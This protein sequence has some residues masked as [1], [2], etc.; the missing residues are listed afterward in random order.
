MQAGKVAN[1]PRTPTPSEQHTIHGENPP[2]RKTDQD[3][4]RQLL[5]AVEGLSM[6]FLGCLVPAVNGRSSCQQIKGGSHAM[7]VFAV[8]TTDTRCTPPGWPR[9][10]GLERLPPNRAPEFEFCSLT[11]RAVGW[12]VHGIAATGRAD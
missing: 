12:L 8:N 7:T 2:D 10:E 5:F 6:G 11:G 9:P 1:I 3:M 4:M